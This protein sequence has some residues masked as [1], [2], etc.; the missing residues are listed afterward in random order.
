MTTTRRFRAILGVDKTD[1]P[2]VLTRAQLMHDRMAAD[3]VTYASPDPPLPAYQIQIQN[4]V[5]AQQ[6]VK[7]RVLGAAAERDVERDLLYTGMGT[8]RMYVQTLAD[9][10]SPGRAVDLIQNAGLLVA[11]LPLSTKPLLKLRRGTP[12]G[13]VIAAANV[14]LLLSA[15]PWV[16]PRASR[17]FNWEATFDGGQT[18]A[19]LPSTNGGKTTLTSLTPLTT[20]GVRV[21]LDAGGPGAWSQMLPTHLVEHLPAVELRA[22]A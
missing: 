1:I 14:G 15:S 4:V 21:N 8:Q 17:F 20:V 16:T 7:T 19:A 22:V 5:L 6:R 11:D 3:D 9:V 12:S 13:T 10:S 2:Q 18:F